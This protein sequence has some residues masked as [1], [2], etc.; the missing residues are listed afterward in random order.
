MHCR[1]DFADFAHRLEKNSLSLC[2]GIVPRQTK[3][4]LNKYL[5]V[6]SYKVIIFIGYS[7]IQFF[8]ICNYNHEDDNGFVYG[9][10][11]LPLPTSLPLTNEPIVF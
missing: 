1:A 5:V 6:L 8:Y 2:C 9:L 7:N 11:R 10:N 4:N 3:L